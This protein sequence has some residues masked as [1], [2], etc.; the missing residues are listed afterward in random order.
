MIRFGR[1]ARVMAVA[2]VVLASGWFGA[3]PALAEAALA[4]PGPTTPLTVHTSRGVFPFAVEVAD[5]TDERS[6]GLMNRRKMAAGHGM[7]FDMTESREASFWMENTYI[8]LDI[9]F[10]GDDGRVITIADNA[11]PLSR[12]LI[13]SKGPSRFVLELVAG[14]AE[15]MGLRR[16]DRISHALIDALAGPP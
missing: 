1:F 7:L 4:K 11:V 15:K 14:S 6:Q 2:L 10:I 3:S 16:G 12:A 5:D 8:A 13:P 9:I